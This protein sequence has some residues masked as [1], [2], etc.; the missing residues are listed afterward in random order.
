MILYPVPGGVRC[1][2]HSTLLISLHSQLPKETRTLTGTPALANQLPG[3][4][5][6]ITK[7]GA[8]EGSM[9]PPL[10]K[11]PPTTS[12][13][14]SWLLNMACLHLEREETPCRQS[15]PHQSQTR[16]EKLLLFSA[17]QNRRGELSPVLGYHAF[18]VSAAIQSPLKSRLLWGSLSSSLSSLS[19]QR[20][21]AG[22]KAL[23][24]P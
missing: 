6:L 4:P 10:P 24:Y 8:S 16:E 3:S 5:F 22:A 1:F 19:A 17:K 13:A 11:P 2:T 15:N 21:P 23:L 12:F 9:Q 7:R 14:A 20:V 18:G